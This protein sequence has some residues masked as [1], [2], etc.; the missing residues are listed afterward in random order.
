MASKSREWRLGAGSVVAGFLVLC[1]ACERPPAEF[2]DAKPTGDI[3][4]P[5][6]LVHVVEVVRDDVG[7]KSTHSGTLRARRTARIFT[8]EEGRIIDLPFFEGDLV[9]AGTSL[10]TLDDALLQARLAKAMARR[11]KFQADVNRLDRLV[12]NRLTTQDELAQV[13][14]SLD[15]AAADELEL[16]T[17]ISYTTIRAPLT[18]VVTER[19]VEP[20]DVVRENTQLMTL[21]DPASLVT[22][23]RVSELLIPHLVQEQSV[24]VRI[25]ALGD[26]RFAG[27]IVRIHPTVDALSRRGILEIALD[28]V[29]AGA[30]AGQLCRVLIKTR[31]Q[32]RKLVPFSAVQRNR[33]GEFV[34]VVTDDDTTERRPVQTGLRLADR[35]EIL[36]GLSDGDRVVIRGFLG[37]GGGKAVE[38]VPTRSADG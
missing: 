8:Q 37:L 19:L 23:I 34:Y 16:L 21:A 38:I 35:I 28:P 29:P 6:H 24:E 2:A 4:T 33:E 13:K 9:D 20:G 30:A 3:A 32:E 11:R 31:S 27:R 18:G 25:D 12:R 15:I 1:A 22:E 7:L 26:Q 10:A 5:P 36:D 17:R 14:M